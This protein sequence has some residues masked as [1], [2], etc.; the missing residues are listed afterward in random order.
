[1]RVRVVRGATEPLNVLTM[2]TRTWCTRVVP[3]DDRW[4][5]C[6]QAEKHQH[7]PYP[8][9]AAV[10]H[11]R[12]AHC[13][14]SC[15]E[16]RHEHG[17]CPPGPPLHHPPKI[18][19]RQRVARPPRARTAS[20]QKRPARPAGAPAHLGR[21]AHGARASRLTKPSWPRP[22]APMAVPT[23]GRVDL[24]TFADVAN[25]MGLLPPYRGSSL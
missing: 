20:A 10:A 11:E 4:K 19:S 9:L 5:P 21:G 13:P 16:A 22:V 15:R 8:R 23:M 25:A 2:S 14:S 24:G 17:S 6:R 12:R 7:L 3:I 1:M 18:R